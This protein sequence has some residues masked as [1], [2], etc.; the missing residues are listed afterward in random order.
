MDTTDVDPTAQPGEKRCTTHLFDHD[1]IPILYGRRPG[2]PI[3]ISDSPN[4]PPPI[5]FDL[6]YG[7]VIVRHFGTPDFADTVIETWHDVFYPDG[8]IARMESEYK[9]RKDRRASDKA[10]ARG[11]DSLDITLVLPYLLVPPDELHAHFQHAK[12]EAED[13]E[14]RRVQE[15]VGNWKRQVREEAEC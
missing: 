10:N 1:L 5:L 4:W 15:K 13:A 2:S 9:E 14:R 8:L 3:Q 12:Q 11:L 6:I 7:D